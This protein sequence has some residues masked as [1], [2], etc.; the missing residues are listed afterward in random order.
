MLR[1]SFIVCVFAA[2]A[3]AHT[4][5]VCDCQ[6]NW[7]YNGATYQG[8]S[9]TPDWAGHD[10]CYLEGGTSCPTYQ[11]STVTGET[12]KWRECSGCN[13]L[14]T[15]DYRTASYQGCS[16]TPDWA[17]HDWCYIQG[18]ST[19]PTY[20]N[21]TEAGEAKKW[22][23]CAPDNCQT[24]WNYGT[25]G[26]L[27]NGCT[28][29]P[30]WA[31][32]D[33]CYI[34]GSSISSPNAKNS[35]VVGE[36]KKW[37]ECAPDNCQ[38]QWN[39][40]TTG[41]VYEGCTETPD[42]AGNDWCYTQ[43]GTASNPNAKDSSVVGED[44][45]WRQCS[46]CNCQVEWNYLG[47]VYKGATATPDY[48]Q[49]WCY[50][51]GGSNCAGALASSV[52]G[53]DR[54]WIHASAC[55]CQTQWNYQDKVYQGC[56]ETPDWVDHRWCYVQG[57]SNC[58]AA[59]TSSVTGEDRRWLECVHRDG[60]STGAQA[61]IITGSIIAGLSLIAVLGYLMWVTPP[62]PQAKLSN[63]GFFGSP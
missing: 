58:A 24:Q 29:T 18:G 9:E 37:R 48:A 12:R 10:W 52:P 54:K 20:Q 26:K 32:H 35:S 28:E 11:N 19:C 17:G 14:T 47:S 31:G 49:S 3:I 57:G 16:E 61:G 43:G 25:T 51:Q 8:C 27:Y 33:W 42:W 50:V 2:F 6:A 23:E 39:Y 56:A 13:C 30:D 63:L 5:A 59:Q 55:D 41:K 34:E 40:G 36:A 46:P 60:L 21:S 15:W 7:A 22:R 44:K 45:K 53:E 62:A 38:V 1:T 4:N